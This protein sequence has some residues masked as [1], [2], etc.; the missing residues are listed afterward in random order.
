MLR[1]VPNNNM[2]FSCSA[3]RSP[4]HLSLVAVTRALGFVEEFL[5][6][7]PV[8]H[9]EEEPV[10]HD[11]EV[12]EHFCKCWYEKKETNGGEW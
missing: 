7:E 8:I 9:D 10:I 3:S 5:E 2:K 1:P 12:V 11:E 6:E 4:K